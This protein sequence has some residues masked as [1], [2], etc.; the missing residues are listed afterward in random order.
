MAHSLEAEPVVKRV[1]ELSLHVSGRHGHRR[2]CL[3]HLVATLLG[4]TVATLPGRTALDRNREGAGTQTTMPWA[5]TAV[6]V[7]CCKR[8]TV[9]Y[10][11]AAGALC[12]AISPSVSL[13]AA[14]RGRME[15]HGPPSRLAVEICPAKGSQSAPVAA[16]EAPQQQPQNGFEFITWH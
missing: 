12:C 4:S 9:D 16:G 15:H 14:E 8:A 3:E 6:L 1:L 10:H 13:I 5:N 7:P 2:L 11:A